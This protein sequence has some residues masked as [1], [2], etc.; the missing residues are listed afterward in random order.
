MRSAFGSVAGSCLALLGL[1]G[2]VACDGADERQC[3]VG[4]DCASG[5]CTP[6]GQCVAVA[7]SE[8]DGDGGATEPETDG[9]TRDASPPGTDAAPAGCVPNQDGLITRE[10]VPLAAGLKATFRVGQNESVSTA[11]TPR[12]D[13]KRDWDFSTAL[14]SDATVVVET[15]PLTG[16]WY[17]ADFP[18]ASYVSKLSTN[19]DA[20]GVFEAT[21]AALLLRGVV[22]STDG[23]SKTNL[24]HD[25]AAAVL[26]YPLK[27]GATW[28]TDANVTGYYQ[29]VLY[30]PVTFTYYTEKY[31]SSVDAAGTLKTP[32]GA[33]EVLRVKT[34]LTRTINLYTVKIRTMTFVTE[35][36]G[37]IATVTSQD[38]ESTEEFTNA[39]EIRRLAP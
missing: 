20:L 31:E 37:A 18:G 33:F 14:S 34:L 1:V 2:F 4:A 16:K 13:G 27:M 19:A 30:G 25:P 10:E 32:L 29:G 23:L 17:E 24:K 9:A 8:D 38:D 12:P 15:Q 6:E 5:A 35:C 21:P 22:S 39:K 36:Y 11:G 28:T 3:H 7:R 26:S